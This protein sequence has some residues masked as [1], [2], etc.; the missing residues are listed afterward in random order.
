MTGSSGLDERARVLKAIKDA[1]HDADA[2]DAHIAGPELVAEFIDPLHGLLADIYAQAVLNRGY[3]SSALLDRIRSMGLGGARLMTPLPGK[4]DGP[5]ANSSANQSVTSPVSGTTIV[6]G[7]CIAAMRAMEAGSVDAVVCDP[8]YGMG[9]QSNWRVA[10][11]QFDAIE[12]DAGFDIA[13]QTSWMTQAYRVLKADAHLYAFCSDHHLGAFRAA[14]VTA[15]FNVKRTLVWVKDAWT[16]GDLEGDYGHMTEFVMFAQ[17]GRRPLNGGRTGNV[18][19]A[20]RVP[21]GALEH[22]TQK[23]LGVLRPLIVKSTDPG[24]LVLDPFA[25]SGSTGVACMEEGRRFLGIEQDPA[26][27]GIARA[28]MAQ[29]N[30]FGE[31]A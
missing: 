14:A 22:P 13:W 7:D 8:P 26:Y 12:Q 2:E 31:A 28:R 16:S 27:V 5:F 18:L 17:K 15:G 30:L 4:T 19:R 29:D 10:T 20:K 23:P 25:G 21:P 1:L 11:R 6:E 9:Y 24:E 3:I